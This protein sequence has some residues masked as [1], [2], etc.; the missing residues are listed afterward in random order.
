MTIHFSAPI[1][2]TM[3]CSPQCLKFKGFSR[4]PCH[5]LSIVVTYHLAW[6]T[7][8]YMYHNFICVCV[9]VCVV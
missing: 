7:T 8:V 3:R 2:F 1:H 6:Y 5:W 4:N 9:C